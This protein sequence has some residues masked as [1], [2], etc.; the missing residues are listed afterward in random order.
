M[1]SS[2]TK[3]LYVPAPL[4]KEGSNEIVVFETDG[5]DSPVI[6]FTDTPDLG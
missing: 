6:T 5:F 1:G 2:A 3:T 4:L